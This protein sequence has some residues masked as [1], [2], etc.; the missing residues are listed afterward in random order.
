MNFINNNTE[1]KINF[2]K[3]EKKINDDNIL[4]T[5]DDFN[6]KYAEFINDIPPNKPI[7]KF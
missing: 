7:K 3:D 6:K 2:N 1:P 5:L 4:K